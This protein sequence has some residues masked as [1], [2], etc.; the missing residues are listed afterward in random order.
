MLRRRFLKLST[1]IG[2]GVFSIDPLTWAGPDNNHERR[3]P[4]HRRRLPLVGHAS[5]GCASPPDILNFM[6]H[7]INRLPY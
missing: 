3:I 7:G 5:A 6:E 2:L 1:V 4:G